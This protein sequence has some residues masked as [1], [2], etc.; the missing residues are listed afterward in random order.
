LGGQKVYIANS[1]PQC[2]FLDPACI[3]GFWHLV[4]PIN[5][6]HGHC[7]PGLIACRDADLPRRV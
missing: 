3:S 7:V 5:H 1:V 6:H 4:G 2:G